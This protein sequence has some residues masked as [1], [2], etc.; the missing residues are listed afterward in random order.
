MKSKSE[1]TKGPLARMPSGLA[2]LLGRF[3]FWT[4]VFLAL[5][6]F[7]HTALKGLRPALAEERRLTREEAEMRTHE[8][9]Q[10]ETQHA[11]EVELEALED[12]IYQERVRR[13]ALFIDAPPAR[14]EGP[15]PYSTPK[16]NP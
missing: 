14:V 4:P 13:A 2:W 8:L 5:A 3:A 10:L 11:L 9:D 1:R 12:P 7:A 15:V 16:E 6:F